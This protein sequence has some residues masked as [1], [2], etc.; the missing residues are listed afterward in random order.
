MNKLHVGTVHVHALYIVY[1]HNQHSSIF[2]YIN[3][4]QEIRR[5]FVTQFG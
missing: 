3:H 4:N 1:V 5:F 2:N